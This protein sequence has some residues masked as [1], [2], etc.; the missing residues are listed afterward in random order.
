VLVK[1]GDREECTPE[2]IEVCDADISSLVVIGVAEVPAVVS[3]CVVLIG[4]RC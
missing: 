1:L 2:R 3:V 4:V